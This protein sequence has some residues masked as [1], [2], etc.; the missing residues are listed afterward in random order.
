M[1]ETAVAIRDL[2]YAWNRGSPPVLQI[3]QLDIARGE[4]VF[5]EGPSG[6]G[7]TT[8]LSLLGAVVVPGSGSVSVMDQ[9]P[10][11]LSHAGRDRFRADFIGFIFQMFNLIPYLSMLENTVLPCHFSSRRRDRAAPGDKLLEEEA[12]RLLSRLGLGGSDSHRA[13][14]GLSVGQQQRVAAARAL[15]GAPEIVIADEPT[16]SLDT[17]ARTGFLELLFEE[18]ER[19]GAT[20]IFVSHDHSLGTLFD[21]RVPLADINRAAH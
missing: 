7:K 17:D 2:T 20:L 9:D 8:L 19:A 16:S 13:V 14:T 4:R 21:R 10:A 15:I 5:I 18:C 12:E 11:A 6:S 1:S 3:D